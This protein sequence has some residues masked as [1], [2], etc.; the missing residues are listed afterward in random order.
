MHAQFVFSSIVISISFS[1]IPL[2]HVTI[3]YTS[4]PA[5][6]VIFSSPLQPAQSGLASKLLE[7]GRDSVQRDFQRMRNLLET[8]LEREAA[9]REKA[10]SEQACS[11]QAGLAS[12]LLVES[13]DSV[14]RDFQ[15]MRT[16]LEVRLEREAAEREK[17]RSEQNKE[18]FH[19]RL[20]EA[21]LRQDIADKALKV[22]REKE[23]ANTI[24]PELMSTIK[25]LSTQE[26]P[27]NSP[28][29]SVSRSQHYS[30]EAAGN[31]KTTNGSPSVPSR[32]N[33]FRSTLAS[34]SALFSYARK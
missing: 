6:Y 12:K 30:D 26:K 13:R 19:R 14:Q 28:P 25:M 18:M 33:G 23:K 9:E 11:E 5:L 22:Q 3:T 10:R 24:T 32:K 1:T 7:E 8:R 31:R 34:V 16:L 29:E 20:L 21:R 27:A 2:P 15:R 4:F 17:A